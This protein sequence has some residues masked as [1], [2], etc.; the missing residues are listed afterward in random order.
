MYLLSQDKQTLM[1]F[2]RVSISGHLGGKASLQ[3][4]PLGLDDGLHAISIGSYPDEAAAAAELQR[5]VNALHAG[6]AVYE[7]N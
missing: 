2:S 7:V 4:Q 3:A 5:I 6:L 1:R